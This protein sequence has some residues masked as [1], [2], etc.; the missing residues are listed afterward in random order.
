MPALLEPAALLWRLGMRLRW[1]ISRPYRSRLPVVCIG[2]PTAGGAGKTP[3][4]M[5]IAEL[6]KE[7]GQQPV[8]LTRGYGGIERGPRLVD[9]IRDTAAQVGD[10]PLLLAEVAPAIVS[11]DRAE[12]ARFA[13]ALD[14]TVIVMDDG[15]H[16]PSLVKDLSILVVDGMLGIGNGQII[17]AGPL[18]A[19]LSFQLARA[20]ALIVVGA[21]GGEQEIAARALARSVPVLR[22]QLVPKGETQ[23]LQA[24]PLFAFA[25]IAHPE[26][27]FRMLERQGATL[28]GQAAFPDHHRFTAAD[29]RKLLALAAEAGAELVTTEKDRVRLAGSERELGTLREATRALPVV[30]KFEDEAAVAALL[31]TAVARRRTTN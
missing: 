21:G 31:E 18:R 20:Q 12:G 19:S 14:G 29:A 22:A 16:N 4:A 26:K 23:W 30:M 27:F 13:E 24:T 10:E 9:S 1:S 3:A 15:F 6:L 7:Q 8:F 2:N 11:A 28:A 5:A 17:P 25:G